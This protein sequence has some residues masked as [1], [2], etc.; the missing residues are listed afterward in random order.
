MAHCP[1]CGRKLH[2]YNWRPDCPGCGVNL[3]YFNSNQILLDES[4]KAEKEH[5]LFQPKID[6][7]KA[8]FAGSKLAI[9][10]I[11]LTLLPVGALFLPLLITGEGK[12]LNV[13]DV[14]NALNAYGLGNV[15]SG[16]LKN[17]ACL[18]AALLLLSAAM[19]IV[20]IVLILMSLGKHGRI[21]VIITYSF[22]FCCAAGAVL[23]AAVSKP[24]SYAVFTEGSSALKIGFGA[25]VYAAL[26]LVLLLY[27]L[28]LIKK[29]IPI[30][31]TQCLI[32][33][34]PS[35]EYFRYIEDGMSKSEIQRKM[36]VALATLDEQLDAELKEEGVETA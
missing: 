17:T 3:N 14:Y 21:R 18:A 23:L 6:R 1:Q 28:F 11:V 13:L 15:F 2:I 5:A 19:I 24:E 25:F 34:L 35:E 26:F 29:G 20:S 22:M 36:L 27:N 32:G 31:Y 33:G 7:A 8:A 9:L 16:A 4:E 10:R 30:K 12:R